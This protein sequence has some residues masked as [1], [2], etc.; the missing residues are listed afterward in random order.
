MARC[1]APGAA[2]NML[3]LGAGGHAKA[4]VEV[5]T[6]CGASIAAYV[7]PR[8]SDWLEARHITSDAEALRL[9]A[10]AIVLGIGGVTAED[11]AARLRLFDTFRGR[12]WSAPAIVHPAATVSPGA[13]LGAGTIILAGAVVQPG[14][15][16]SEASLLNTGAIVEHDAV[17]GRGAHVGPGAII[18]GAARV[19]AACL[20]GAGAVLLPGASA[21]DGEVVGSL[22]RHPGGTTAGAVPKRKGEGE[23]R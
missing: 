9:P 14:A 21:G 4:V 6:E 8:P 16:V 12:G 19:G 18:L 3:L 2:V 7:D 11:L 22:T 17:I 23:Q 15:T 1:A 5:L 13:A 20:V 10:G